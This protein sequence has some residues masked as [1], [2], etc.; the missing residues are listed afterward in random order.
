[1]K[2][3]FLLTVLATSFCLTTKLSAQ[4][5]QPQ[6][7]PAGNPIKPI[8]VI[9]TDAVPVTPVELAP[10]L[11]PTMIEFEKTSYDFGDIKQGETVNYMYK[12]KNT[13][14]NPAV[15]ENVKPGCG[16]TATDYTKGEIAPGA[17]GY[18]KL[19][20]N[21]AYKSGLQSKSATVTYNGDPKVLVLSFKANILV[22]PAPPTETPATPPTGH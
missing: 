4:S 11:P 17:E 9:P 6:V 20:F 1:M 10:A 21:S 7:D 13:G 16:C 18:V 5:V 19:E 12:F 22:P 8:E 2:K 15:I 3:F 14:T